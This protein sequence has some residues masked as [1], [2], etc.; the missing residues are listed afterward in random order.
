M[1]QW[2]FLIDG[3]GI[4]KESSQPRPSLNR[5]APIATAASG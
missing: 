2:I 1:N 4:Q 5:V 3:Y